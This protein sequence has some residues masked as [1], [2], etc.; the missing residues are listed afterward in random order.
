[1][2]V[3][4]TVL[5]R[6]NADH[7]RSVAACLVQG[8]YSLQ[9]DR[10]RH[11]KREDSQALAP[12][13]WESFHFELLD[14]LVDAADLSIFGAIYEYK[15]P[16]SH[17]NDS[18][19]QRPRYVIAFRGTLKKI[20][21]VL[22]DGEL[23]FYLIQNRLHQK[24]RFKIGVQAV[25]DKVAAVGDSNVWLAGHSLGAAMA[26]LAGKTMA[27]RGIFLESFLFNP[28]FVSV[29]IER[30]NNKILKNGIRIT[31]SVITA[32][33]ALAVKAKNQNQRNVSGDPFA[34]LSAWLPCLFVNQA[35]PICCEYIGYF[36]HRRQMEKIGAGCIEKI[37]TQHS[38]GSLLKSAEGKDSEAAEPVH[39]IPS[40]NL[41]VNQTPTEDFKNAHGIH[42]WW[43]PD[44]DLHPKLYRYW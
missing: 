9:H 32:G 16:P 17:C 29:P 4:I 33:L 23:S 8:V 34:A 19:E 13:W 35:D 43:R 7:R 37:A 15:P 2:V 39:L 6:T 1:M 5:C 31:G 44:L 38:F 11:E 10:H 12:P 27:K 3:E 30:I 20:D 41:T 14:R 40:A 21:T 24:S 26:M 42:Q 18:I 25:Q 28:P 36:E 22:R